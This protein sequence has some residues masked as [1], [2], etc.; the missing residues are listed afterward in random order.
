MLDTKM[1][2]KIFHIDS[3]LEKIG[4]FHPNLLRSPL[5]TNCG[6]ENF[7]FQYNFDFHEISCFFQKWTDFHPRVFQNAAYW[8]EFYGFWEF[9]SGFILFGYLRFPLWLLKRVAFSL[10]RLEFSTTK[11]K[12]YKN[13]LTLRPSYDFRWK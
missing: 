12:F 2:C 1:A 10:P 9:S 7:I 13:A 11:F 5:T 3:F 8:R 4:H 6:R